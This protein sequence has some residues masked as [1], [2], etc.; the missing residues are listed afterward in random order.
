MSNK[1]RAVLIIIAVI[2]SSTMI[3]SRPMKKKEEVRIRPGI[4]EVTIGPDQDGYLMMG[5]VNCSYGISLDWIAATEQ[6]YLLYKDGVLI[7]EINSEDA[8]WDEPYPDGDWPECI[9][10]DGTGW[11]TYWRFD[12]LKLQKPGDYTLVSY[13][14]INTHLTDGGDYDNDGY[15]DWW[16]GPLYDG[17]ETI[18]HVYK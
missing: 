18:I 12:R 5:Y 11:Y 4:E 6:Q 7:Q 8:R 16:D 2:I 3:S 1:K 13:F 14:S 9:Y 10:G 15:V 17:Y